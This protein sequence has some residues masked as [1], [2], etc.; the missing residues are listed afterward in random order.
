MIVA[1]ASFPGTETKKLC[2]TLAMRL[3]LKHLSR[4]IVDA[5]AI[6]ASSESSRQ[7]IAEEE[8]KGNF[9]TD[10]M[11]ACKQ[12][13]KAVKIFLHSARKARAKQVSEREKI[14][15]GA[16]LEKIEEEEKAL[17][18]AIAAISGTGYFIPEEF[19]MVLNLDRLDEE[20]TIALVEKFLEKIKK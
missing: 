9:I 6:A 3:G 20:A 12:L 1:I 8:S 15:M 16:A 5:K 4:E 14:S 19:D 10:S 11:I 13:Q 18:K 7:E 2:K 17:S